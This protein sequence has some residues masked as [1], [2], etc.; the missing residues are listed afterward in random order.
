MG[1][2]LAARPEG[3]GSNDCC[4]NDSAFHFSL[5]QVSFEPFLTRYLLSN[6]QVCTGTELQ[7]SS[8]LTTAS[9]QCDS[10]HDRADDDHASDVHGLLS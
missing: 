1:H 10:S 2:F 6:R 7:G 4:E 3:H 9:R 5:R 8:F